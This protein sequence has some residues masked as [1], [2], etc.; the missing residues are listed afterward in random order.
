MSVAAS[1]KHVPVLDSLRAFAA[2]SV[3][4]FHFIC[5]VTGFVDNAWIRSFFD[6][7]HYGV[8]LF[9]VISGFI[10]PWSLYHSGYKIRNFFTFAGKRFLRLEPPYIISLIV[11]ITHTF[12]R[13]LSPHYNGLDVTPSIKQVMLHFGYMIPF[14]EG[15]KWIRPVYWTLAIEFQYYITIGLLFPLLLN[16][17]NSWRYLCYALM[18]AGPFFLKGFLPFYF[19][20]FLL[21]ISL[22]LYKIKAINM[23]EL[24]IIATLSTIEIVIFHDF[25]TLLFSFIGFFSI[26]Y[27]QHFKSSILGFFGDISYSIYLF[28]S[29]TGLVLINYFSHTIHHPVLKVLLIV[30]ATGVTIGASY[31]IFR[32]V[33][34][35]SKKLSSSIK[36]NKKKD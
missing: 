9:F 23:I 31:L 13:M 18:F 35:P 10:I 19:P 25:G 7:G 2:L 1:N 6:Y 17:K 12:V 21:G 16:K 11:A 15:E 24:C 20:V 27:F 34:L 26:L 4:L 32:F 33:E 5:T 28:H 8:Q 22:C 30:L 36:F 14:F 3:C 29:L